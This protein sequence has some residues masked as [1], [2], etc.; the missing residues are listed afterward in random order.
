VSGANPR[1]RL[2]ATFVYS[3]TTR[4]DGHFSDGKSASV[5]VVGDVVAGGLRK[6]IGDATL[7]NVLCVL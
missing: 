4:D 5:I 3:A 6:R 1:S 7:Q 2:V